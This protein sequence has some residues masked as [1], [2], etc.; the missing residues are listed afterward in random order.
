MDFIDLL[1]QFSASAEKRKE[2]IQYEITGIDDLFKYKNTFI[3]IVK[4]YAEK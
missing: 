4:R 2:S 3:E 1:K